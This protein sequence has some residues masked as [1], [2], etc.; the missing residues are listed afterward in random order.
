MCRPLYS[1]SAVWEEW[2]SL[3]SGS[4]IFFF[5]FFTLAARLVSASQILSHF[6][7]QSYI[8]AYERGGRGISNAKHYMTCTD[9]TI[10]NSPLL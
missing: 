1:V 8:M 10:A 7:L 3:T 5:F 6:N 9:Y 2:T 4:H